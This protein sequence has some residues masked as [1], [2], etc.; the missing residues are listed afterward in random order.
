MKRV[1]ALVVS[2]MLIVG[3]MAGCSTKEEPSAPAVAD[4]EAETVAVKEEPKAENITLRIYAQYSDDDTIIPFDYAVAELAKAYPNVTLELDIQAQDDGQKLQTYAATGN[5]PDIFQVGLSQIETFK[6]SGNIMILD[7]AAKSSG[8]LDKAHP[9]ASNI[10]YNEDGHIYAFPYAGNELVMWYYNKAIFEEYGVKVP[11]TYE[12]LLTAIEV[13][14]ANDIIPMSIFA[15]EKWITTALYDVF[16]TRFAPEGI[17]SLD[18]GKSSASDEAYTMAAQTLKDLLAVGFLPEGAT[19][20][21]YDQAAS[22]FYEGKAAMF[23]NGQWEMEASTEKLGENA[24]WMWYPVMPGYEENAKALSG[25]GAPGGY[26]VSPHSENKEL[27]A[28]VAAFISEKYCEAKYTKRSNPILA[29]K[30]DESL[31][32]EKPFP[33]MMAK[34]SEEMSTITSTTKFAWG[35]SNPQFKV[36]IEDQSQFLLTPD[37]TVAEFVEEIDKTIERMNK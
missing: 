27:A 20:L 33:A 29:L 2:M 11:E 16:A 25:G 35:L 34:L 5:L 31:Q 23:L 37:Y 26:A 10:I 22:L 28:E 21:N 32:P 14:N 17:V 1:L 3:M 15:K 4:K 18:K 24:D 13:F 9:S 8:Y 12:E 36:A 30:I 6:E 19:N 7:D